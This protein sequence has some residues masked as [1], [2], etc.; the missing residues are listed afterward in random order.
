MTLILSALIIIGTWLDVAS[1]LYGHRKY[2]LHE[3]N[4]I[5]RTLLPH[6]V[7]F[8]A[9]QTAFWGLMIAVLFA[10]EATLEMFI[11]LCVVRFGTVGW[12][13]AQIVKARNNAL[14]PK[15]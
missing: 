11:V 15:G 14:K 1:T 10:G 7:L 13:A 2:R 3:A 5:W 4:A 6:P 9:A 12:N 8:Y